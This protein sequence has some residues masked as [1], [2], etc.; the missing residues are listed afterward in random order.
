MTCWARRYRCVACGVTCTVLPVG[1]LPRLWYSLAAIVRALVLVVAEPVGQGV[2]ERTAYACQG[3]SPP[4][5]WNT[6]SPYRWRSLDRWKRRLAQWWPS[7][8]VTSAHA[9][10]VGFIAEAGDNLEAILRR[11][12]ASHACWGEAM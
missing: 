12:T 11:A 5:S 2:D 1:V 9:L 3:R 6:C 7:R 4:P 10:L 8:V